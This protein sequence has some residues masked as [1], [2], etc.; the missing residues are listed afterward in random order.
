MFKD[1]IPAQNL[2]QFLKI[3]GSAEAA[4]LDVFTD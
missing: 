2:M 1:I 3:T 4:S